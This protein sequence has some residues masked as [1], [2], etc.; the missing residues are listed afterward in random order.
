MK[1]AEQS[2]NIFFAEGAVPTVEELAQAK[3]LGMTAFRNAKKHGSL[4]VGE[5]TLAGKVPE[6]YRKLPNV[7]VVATAAE[8]DAKAQA[9]AEAKAQAEADALKSRQNR[10]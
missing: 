10:R 8:V 6:R 2:R 7:K 9:D 1:K 4:P 3:A 5:C